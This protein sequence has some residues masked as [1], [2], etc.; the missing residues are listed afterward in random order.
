VVQQ[1][2]NLPRRHALAK[3]GNDVHEVTT[4]DIPASVSASIFTQRRQTV[5]AQTRN[6]Y[7]RPAAEVEEEI[8]QRLGEPAPGNQ[9]GAEEPQPERQQDD[10]QP[11]AL[12]EEE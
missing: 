1:I 12:Y 5:V 7:C 4:L 3:I 6:K 2:I 10:Q 11:S 9:P 8:M